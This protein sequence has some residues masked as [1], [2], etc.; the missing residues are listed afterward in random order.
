MRRPQNDITLPIRDLATTSPHQESIIRHSRLIFLVRACCC[1]VSN[2]KCDVILWPTH[3]LG[4]PG[5][6][7]LYCVGHKMTSHF[8]LETSQQQA[9]TRNPSFATAV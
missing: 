6:D 4:G 1:E 5:Q 8:Q 3:Q 7:V 9:L 2:W